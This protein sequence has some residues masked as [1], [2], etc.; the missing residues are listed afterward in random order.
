MET[1]LVTLIEQFVATKRI[2]GRAETTVSWHGQMLKSPAPDSP[3]LDSPARIVYNEIGRTNQPI[4]EGN[5][6]VKG[7]DDSLFRSLNLQREGLDR[8]I[9]D[10]LQD[11]IADG[12]LP[13]GSQLPPERE[14]AGLLGVNRATLREA[15]RTLE[16]RGLVKMK[17]GSGT[18]VR[19]SM[20]A[21]FMAECIEREFVFGDCSHDDLVTLR[22]ILEPEVAALAAAK[23][24]P[25]DLACL[26]ELAEQIE[27]AFFNDVNN[28]PRL[29]MAFHEALAVAAGNALISAISSGLHRVMEVWMQAQLEAIKL[30]SGARSHRAVYEAVAARDPDRAREA[31][32]YHMTTTRQSQVSLSGQPYRARASRD[33]LAAGQGQ[34]P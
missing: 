8:Q 21:S 25:E 5:G 6:D 4:A 22:E 2:E 20:P 24:T 9:A 31:M 32:R 11:M 30:E 28:Y 14:L 33:N 18:Y 12:K 17:V 10:A 13:R 1:S 23:A 27:W 7:R 3:A 29:D 34:T 19:E 16:Q 26:G 15:I